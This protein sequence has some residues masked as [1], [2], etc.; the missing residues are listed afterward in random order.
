MK[1]TSLIIL[2]VLIQSCA[3]EPKPLS[4]SG[5]FQLAA[6]TIELDSS[7]FKKSAQVQM[8]LGLP[9]VEIRYSTDGNAVDKNSTLYTAPFQIGESMVIKAKA[10]HK[11]YLESGTSEVHSTQIKYNVS[12]ALV[13]LSTE[14]NTNYKG[15]GASGLV[16]MQKGTMQFRGS[17]Q[18]LGFQE[19]EVKVSIDLQKE[20]QL[21]KIGLSTLVNQDGWIFSPQKVSVFANDKEIGAT[22][23]DD[24]NKTQANQLQMIPVPITPA[25]YQKLTIVIKSL[26]EIPQWHQGKGTLPWL[27]I[28][29]IILE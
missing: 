22:Q 17:D 29:E 14:A 28:D 23:L 6:P 20:I 15:N 26:E 3:P 8:A 11:D 19:K 24:A 1:W 25:N 16:D 10:F 18:W 4:Q 21:S 13:G 2:L 27:F 5:T 9:N 12:N 7:I